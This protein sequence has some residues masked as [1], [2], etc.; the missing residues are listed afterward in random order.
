[1]PPI[2]ITKP[3]DLE[4]LK[5]S[6]KTVDGATR[7]P[8]PEQIGDHERRGDAVNLSREEGQPDDRVLG[9]A[10]VVR[11]TEPSKREDDFGHEVEEELGGRVGQEQPV[12]RLPAR[13]EKADGAHEPDQGRAKH[14][15]AGSTE[16]D[17]VE[18]KRVLHA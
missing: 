1:M 2:G 8:I 14:E 7:P 13:P 17:P 4:R 18:M 9:L 6:I 10:E 15:G 3:S 12:T 16:R 5:S 11:E